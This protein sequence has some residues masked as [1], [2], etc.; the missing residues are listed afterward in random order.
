MKRKRNR[1][2]PCG[3]KAAKA[4]KNPDH[5]RRIPKFAVED[6]DQTEQAA[7]DLNTAT[8]EALQRGAIRAEQI[9]AR[10]EML[11]VTEFAK[12][13]GMSR[14]AVRTVQPRASTFRGKANGLHEL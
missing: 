1:F 10:S 7:L 11:S 13:T 12:F 3:P 6:A 5:E 9:L 8:E 4:S 2:T 14:E